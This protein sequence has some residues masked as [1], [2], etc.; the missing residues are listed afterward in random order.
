MGLETKSRLC[1]P[2]LWGPHRGLRNQTPFASNRAFPLRGDVSYPTT[3]VVA[4]VER[5]DSVLRASRRRLS[6]ALPGRASPV[7]PHNT[8]PTPPLRTFDCSP[9]RSSVQYEVQRSERML[10]CFIKPAA[11]LSKSVVGML[12]PELDVRGLTRT[13]LTPATGCLTPTPSRWSSH[14]FR[15]FCRACRFE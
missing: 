10:A 7:A 12:W 5:L 9:A 14:V 13:N 15:L 3:S 2:A 4:A 6:C 8:R 11:R 1:A